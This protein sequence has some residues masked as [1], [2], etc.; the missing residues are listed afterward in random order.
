MYVGQIWVVVTSWAVVT[1]TCKVRLDKINVAV[2]RPLDIRQ[3]I[4]SP[5]TADSRL[6]CRFVDFASV[7]KFYA[8]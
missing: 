4:N 2:Y 3:I 1:F 5:R 7:I 6:R 8:I